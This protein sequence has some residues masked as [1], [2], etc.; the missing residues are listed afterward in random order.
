MTMTLAQ[1]INGQSSLKQTG[2]TTIPAIQFKTLWVTAV[3]LSSQALIPA[4]S[5]AQESAEPAGDPTTATTSVS[6]SGNEVQSGGWVDS[7]E[8][9]GDRSFTIESTGIESTSLESTSIES[10]SLEFGSAATTLAEFEPWVS[11]QEANLLAQESIPVPTGSGETI[12]DMQVRFVDGSGT[13]VD[14]AYRD[15]IILREF[16]LE[17][18]DRYNA[19]L[20]EEGLMRVNGLSGVS[21]ASLDLETDQRGGAVMVVTVREGTPGLSLG[22]HFTIVPGRGTSRPS[23][24]QGLAAVPPV[25]TGVPRMTGFKAPLRFQYFNIGGRDQTLTVGT[26]TGPETVG[27][28]LTYR[29]PWIAGTGNRLGWAINAFGLSYQPPGFQNGPNDVDLA[30]DR[31]PWEN[32][33]GGGIE[34]FQQVGSNLEVATGLSYQHIS[35]SDSA[36]G[37]RFTVDEDGNPLTVSGKD[38]DDLLLLTINTLAD[39]RNRTIFPTQGNRFQ[40]GVDQAIPVGDAET[41]FTRLSANY[42]QFLPVGFIRVPETSGALIF[43]V[44]GGTIPFDAPPGYEAYVLGGSSSVR[45]YST[46]EMGSPRNFVQGTLEYRFP[47]ASID[48][49]S[50]L[51]QEILGEDWVIAGNVFFDAA[52]GFDTDDEVIGRPGDARDKTGEGFGYGVGL[53]TTSNIG[54]IRMEFGIADTGDTNFIFT[55]GDR[56]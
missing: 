16:D 49:G 44:Q 13:P 53:L 12:I 47:F 4:M 8:A 7:F 50:G 14:G 2:F 6:D 10:T 3:L 35:F 9:V 27:V 28:D 18:G 33:F 43:N 17:P 23:A 54:L 32:R 41:M 1:G 34:F 38:H 31:D 56:F 29:D 42:T 5:M 40:A 15:Y 21:A 55:I 37:D 48:I 52:T 30:N 26:L 24:L 25:R 45:G 46:G 20:A 22:R 39:G 51:F 19:E 11:T 36:L